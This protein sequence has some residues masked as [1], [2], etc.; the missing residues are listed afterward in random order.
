MSDS[1]T[2][3]DIIEGDVL[4][5][6][7]DVLGLKYA[8]HY[9]GSDKAVSSLLVERGASRAEKLRPSPGKHVWI[10]PKSLLAARRV[11]FIGV[12]A[13]ENFGYPEIE[14]FAFEVLRI[15]AQELPD[16]QH[17]AITLHGAGYGLDEVE[18]LY[19]ELRGLT[20][21]LRAG[22]GPAHLARISIVERSP[23]RVQRLRAALAEV[24]STVLSLPGFTGAA[25]D[26]TNLNLQSTAKVASKPRVFVAM[27]FSKGMEDVFYF[28]IQNP[29][30]ELGYICE[31][32]DQEA[33]TGDILQQ[34]RSRIEDADIV[35]ADL[36]GKNPNVYLEVGYAWGKSRP[37]VLLIKNTEELPF[38]VRGQRCL[39]YETIRDLELRLTNELK[40]LNASTHDTLS[41]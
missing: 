13:L 23:D 2:A 3:L 40:N 28:G 32:V 1:K 17:V 18:A 14:Q 25:V 29:V 11:L 30:R 37:T 19:S 20:K 27:P 31:R 9:Y 38:D 4:E 35:I 26:P 39:I 21:A 7:A 33:F 12:P 24:S 10:D 41:R 8:Q 34:V 16:S 15:S 36:T 6:R 5:F 22:K